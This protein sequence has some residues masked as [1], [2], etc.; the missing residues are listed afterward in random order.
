MPIAFKQFLL[1]CLKQSVQA[2]KA[3]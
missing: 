3:A 2:L 1:I